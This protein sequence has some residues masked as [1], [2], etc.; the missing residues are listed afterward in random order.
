MRSKVDTLKEWLKTKKPV[1]VRK[2]PTREEVKPIHIDSQPFSTRAVY[3]CE[4][5]V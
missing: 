2:E 1:A 5:P 3:I 4:Q